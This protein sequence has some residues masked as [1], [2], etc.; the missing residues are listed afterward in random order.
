MR[1]IKHEAIQRAVAMGVPQIQRQ[2][3]VDSMKAS[4]IYA[5][6]SF[7]WPCPWHAEVSRPGIKPMPQQQQC[8]ILNPLSHQGIPMFTFLITT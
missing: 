4:L 5:S 8:R 7:V 6:F 3:T 1:E 2:Q